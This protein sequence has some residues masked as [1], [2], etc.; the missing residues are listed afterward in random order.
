MT[1]FIYVII[2]VLNITHILFLKVM[3]KERYATVFYYTQDNVWGYTL[4]TTYSII[5]GITTSQFI[6]DMNISDYII[7][8]ISFLKFDW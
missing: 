5:R 8:L 2:N 1:M 4:L 3:Q 6:T 7:N